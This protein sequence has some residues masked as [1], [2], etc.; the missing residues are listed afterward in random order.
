[1]GS[2][3]GPPT[4]RP[5]WP[6]PRTPFISTRRPRAARAGACARRSRRAS[7]STAKS[8]SRTRWTGAR[9]WRELA[10]QRGVKHG[11]VQDKLFLPGIRKLKRLV[12]GGFFGRILSVRGEFGY[13]V[14]EGDWQPAQRPSWNYRAED[15]GGIIMDMLC[16]WR[17]VLDNTFGA[18]AARE[19]P[20]RDAHSGALGRSRETIRLHGG[21]CRLRMFRAG[22]RRGRADQFVLERARVSRR[23]VGDP[24]GRHARAARSRV[25]ANAGCSIARIRRGR[26]GIRTFPTR[27]IFAR[28]GRR[29]PTTRNSTTRSRSQWEMFLRHVE[30][31]DAVPARFDGRREGRAAGGA[32]ARSRGAKGAGWM[33][34]SWRRNAGDAC[35]RSMA[36]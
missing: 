23:T 24:G 27:S 2:R 35:F 7:T 21:R 34:R 22:R 3:A 6:I 5:A 20:G 9:D 11:V 36:A 13:W 1:M 19:L 15:G 18:G 8:R 29:F 4:W 31:G 32:G 16:H 33:C 30:L 25:C 14:F 12:D 26:S 28:V 10:R 17:Y